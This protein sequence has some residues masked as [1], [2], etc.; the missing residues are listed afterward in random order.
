MNGCTARRGDGGAVL[1]AVGAGDLTGNP[2]GGRYATASTLTRRY[3]SPC[4]STEQTRTETLSDSQYS[5]ASGDLIAHE[6]SLA[7]QR[8][9]LP[10]HPHTP[11]SGHG[12]S[13]ATRARGLDSRRG[14]CCHSA[15]RGISNV[16][17]GASFGVSGVLLPLWAAAVR[18]TSSSSG[19]GP[20]P[21]CEKVR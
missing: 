1:H 9:R 7:H 17:R 13:G 15:C 16:G 10:S 12:S 2:C 20:V 11:V 19:P 14:A 21:L 18:P 6:P 8:H 3:V 5:A 4:W